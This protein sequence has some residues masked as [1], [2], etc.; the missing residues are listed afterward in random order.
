MENKIETKY[1]FGISTKSDELR[2]YEKKYEIIEG[3]KF[4]RKAKKKA[5]KGGSNLIGKFKI[6]I[7]FTVQNVQRSR[8]WLGGGMQHDD[9]F[10]S[11]EWTE[12]VK[13]YDKELLSKFIIESFLSLG[14]EYDGNTNQII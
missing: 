2:I 1:N 10:C 6:E 4:V 7:P 14:I 9:I 3:I 11:E 12:S 8:N 13:V 5:V